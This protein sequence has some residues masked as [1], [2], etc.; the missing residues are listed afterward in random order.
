MWHERWLTSKRK[1]RTCIHHLC[2]L[3]AACIFNIFLQVQVKFCL[4]FGT[5]LSDIWFSSYGMQLQGDE[6]LL[7]IINK[8][9][10]YLGAQGVAFDFG[11]VLE[12]WFVKRKKSVDTLAA[13]IEF[14]WSEHSWISFSVHATTRKLSEKDQ[15]NST[16]C[17]PY[18]FARTGIQY[19][20]RILC[21]YRQSIVVHRRGRTLLD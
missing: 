15:G 20:F 10:Y 16:P 17:G 3:F 4:T 13:R 14:K 2:L 5:V 21:S 7:A 8:I 12:I 11:Q 9:F 19:V 1:N 18:S 6:S